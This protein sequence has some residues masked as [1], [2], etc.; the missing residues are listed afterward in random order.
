MNFHQWKWDVWAHGAP[1]S[2]LR[3]NSSSCGRR[4]PG[5]S[6]C[7]LHV[8]LLALLLPSLAWLKVLES[9]GVHLGAPLRQH[10]QELRGQERPSLTPLACPQHPSLA[11]SGQVCAVTKAFPH[12]PALPSKCVKRHTR[13]QPRVTSSMGGCEHAW[14]AVHA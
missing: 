8:V 7:A 13:G 6:P 2:S 3:S 5:D 4:V 9:E 14:E 10:S 1:S 11:V 12:P